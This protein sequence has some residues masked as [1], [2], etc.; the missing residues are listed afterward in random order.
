MA[1]T[2]LVLWVKPDCGACERARELMASLSV[3][4]QFEWS[5][6]SGRFS[7][8][9]PVVA[10]ADGQVLARAPID[11]GALVDA[12]VALSEPAEARPPD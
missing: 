1:E 3:A 7:D 8:D 10:T 6:Q 5:A 4:M 11:A 12:I 9:V 2:V